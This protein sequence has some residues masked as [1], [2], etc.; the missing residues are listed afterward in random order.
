MN[1]NKKIY[2]FTFVFLFGI[3]LLIIMY[4]YFGLKEAIYAFKNIKIINLLIIILLSFLI[5]IF[6]TIRWNIIL[7]SYKIKIN[8]LRLLQYKLAAFSF[9]Y[10]SPQ[11]NFGGDPIKALLLKKENITFKKGFSTVLIDRIIQIFTDLVF[12]FFMITFIILNTKIKTT[13]KII[14]FFIIILPIVILIYYFNLMKNEKM[15]LSNIF[16]IK[17]IKKLKKIEKNIIDI[18][19]IISNFYS[20]NYKIFLKIITLNFIVIILIVTQYYFALNLLNL[21][22]T[23]YNI[24][25]VLISISIA[26]FFPMPMNL[27]GLEFSQISALS[28]LKMDKTLGL[29]LSILIRLIDLIKTFI[30][31]NFLF[32]YGI[33]FKKI[34]NLLK[35]KKINIKDNIKNKKK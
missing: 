30:G 8:F 12:A 25:V 31:L 18:E 26:S 4:L 10:L 3:F 35:I 14:I 13:T 7:N 27:G 20:K 34:L 16:K 2:R 1:F 19:K 6:L 15:F 29:S 9:G 5:E 23:F 24:F 28:F 32:Y 22:A 21:K 33:N 11:P 17:V